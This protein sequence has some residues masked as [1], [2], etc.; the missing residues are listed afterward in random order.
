[1]ADPSWWGQELGLSALPSKCPQSLLPS[2][3]KGLLSQ[4][5]SCG[6]LGQAYGS[7]VTWATHSHFSGPSL[8]QQASTSVMMSSV[9]R[10][11]GSGRGTGLRWHFSVPGRK[12][13]AT[14]RW[15]SRGRSRCPSCLGLC[16]LSFS[17]LPLGT[18]D[19]P[20]GG[21]RLAWSLRHFRLVVRYHCHPVPAPQARPL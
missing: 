21:M 5:L 8:H 20:T 9:S 19:T 15:S 3:W 10:P 6:S 13:K 7:R 1:M 2:G 11:W 4:G 12:R 14:C 16:C 17:L 18:A